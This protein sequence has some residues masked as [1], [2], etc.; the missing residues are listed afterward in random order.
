MRAHGKFREPC[1]VCGS[2]IQRVVW[3]E[4][5][6]NYCAVCQT[7][8]KVLSDRVLAPLFGKSW[9]GWGLKGDRETRTPPRKTRGDGKAAR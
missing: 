9:K 3:A 4:N 2:P 7:G 8:G 1:P 5:E 6:M